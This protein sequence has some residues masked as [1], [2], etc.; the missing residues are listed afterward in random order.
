MYVV[1]ERKKKKYV[2]YDFPIIK[3]FVSYH[4]FNI[5]N[6]LNCVIFFDDLSKI[7]ALGSKYIIFHQRETAA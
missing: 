5:V 7:L 6:A 4:E 1:L 3:T 2:S